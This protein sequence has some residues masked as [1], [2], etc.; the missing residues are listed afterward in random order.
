MR[1]VGIFSHTA[2]SVFVTHVYICLSV[3]VFACLSVV[4]ETLRCLC[5]CVC[6]CD[7]CGGSLYR[8][9]HFRCLFCV[10]NIT[11]DSRVKEEML[12]F[13]LFFFS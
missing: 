9:G 5:V 4:S 8:F 11:E 6:M 10:S 7:Q 2:L 12:M 3:F 13:P 1:P